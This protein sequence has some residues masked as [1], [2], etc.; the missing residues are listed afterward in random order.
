[1]RL[2]YRRL[3]VQNNV[4]SYQLQKIRETQELKLHEQ[5]ANKAKQND[6]RVYEIILF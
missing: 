5:V 3:R 2:R 4:F 6:N 1:M